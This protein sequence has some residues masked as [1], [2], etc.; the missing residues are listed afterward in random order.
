MVS[1]VTDMMMGSLR[2][3]VFLL[4]LSLIYVTMRSA[5][6]T[7]V[8]PRSAPEKI[9]RTWFRLLRRIFDLRLHWTKDYLQRDRIMAVYAPLALLSLLPIWLLFVTLGFACLYWAT[10]MNSQREDLILSGSSLLTLGFARGD[11]PIHDLLA[12]VEATLGLILVA[13]LIAY[14]PAMYGAFSRRE[15]AVSRLAVR[16]GTPPSA[17]EFILRAQ[18]INALNNMHD[19]WQEWEIWFAEIEESH[20]SLAA[21]V[22]FRSPNPLHSWVTASGA[23]LDTAAIM[24]STVDVLP[25]PQAALCIRA[26]YLALQS[27]G[28]FFNVDFPTSPLFPDEPISIMRTEFD[29]LCNILKDKGVPLKEDLDQAWLDFGGWRVNYD[30]VLLALATLT[31]APDAHWSTDRAPAYR[32]MPLFK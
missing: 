6:I 23:V 16:A 11:Y 29:E 24:L 19:F 30:R 18:R 2:L 13:V 25:Q 14:L 8:L 28:K 5:L 31:M 22:F 26:G 7:F 32:P 15:S 12:F 4:G 20:T 27:I 3:F 17:I 21:L 10:G 1:F 9:S